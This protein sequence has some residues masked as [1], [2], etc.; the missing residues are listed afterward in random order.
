MWVGVLLLAGPRL[1]SQTAPAA[2]LQVAEILRYTLEETQA[3]IA[4]GMGR[5]AQVNDA[6]PV[7]LTWHYQTDLIDVHEP[8]HVLLLRKTTG[9]LVSVTRNYHYPVNVDVLF[10]AGKS[11]IHHWP[12]AKQPQL[13]VQ[14]R[15]YA[16]DRVMIAMGVAKPGQTTTQLI[17]MRR[18][19]LRTFFPWLVLGD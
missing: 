16:G 10:P 15:E 1:F 2:P 18:T 12:D 17:V 13:S 11:S 9:K 19:A 5:P 8:T 3:Q 14:V 7:F 4:R 6:D